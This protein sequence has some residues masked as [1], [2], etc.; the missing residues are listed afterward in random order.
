MKHLIHIIVCLGILAVLAIVYTNIDILLCDETT[1]PTLPTTSNT[2]SLNPT[3]QD[4]T[5]ISWTE[6]TNATSSQAQNT[7][8]WLNLGESF[9][10][11]ELLAEGTL[12]YTITNARLIDCLPDSSYIEDFLHDDFMLWIDGAGWIQRELPIYITNDLNVCD[13]DYLIFVDVTIESIGARCYTQ[14]DF[15]DIGSSMGKYEDPYIFRADRLLLINTDIL[16]PL[17]DEAYQYNTLCYYSQKDDH[18]NYPANHVT[19]RLEPGE[20]ISFTVGYHLDKTI[21]NLA[22]HPVDLSKFCVT[23]LPEQ[24]GQL[25]NL[26]L[27]GIIQ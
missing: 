5:E 1:A 6:A 4:H 19:Y 11:S 8:N 20:I 3:H 15:D 25:V 17:A 9:D 24:H 22:K 27:E 13:G 21:V 12:R 7:T 10:D 26:N 18:P 16:D 23:T 2:I 14:S